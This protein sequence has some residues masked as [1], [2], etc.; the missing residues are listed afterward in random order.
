VLSVNYL[1]ENNLLREDVFNC[2]MITTLLLP[3]L[4]VKQEES[5]I[6]NGPANLFK[7]K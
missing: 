1:N 3:V 4:E 5:H 7:S 2:I 6:M